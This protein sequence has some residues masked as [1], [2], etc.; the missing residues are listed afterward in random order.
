M[1]HQTMIHQT[2]IYQIQEILYIERGGKEQLQDEIKA[3]NP[4]VPKGNELVAT[5]M[6][7]IDNE[8][9]FEIFPANAQ[10]NEGFNA[11]NEVITNAVRGVSNVILNPATMNVDFAD[12]QAAMSQK[13]MAIMCIGK[14]KGLNRA[15]DAVNNALDN[16]FFNKAEVKNAKGLLINI[17]GASGMEMQEIN[18]IMKQAQSISQQ[19]VEA[20]PG[21]TIDESY[22]D[23]IVVTIIATG[24]RKFNLDEFS[25][26]Y[27]RPVRDIS[28]VRKESEAYIDPE[29]L[30]LIDIHNVIRSIED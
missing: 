25:N 22:G 27:I 10:F 29:R 7:E 21:L 24:L 4:L 15:I 3:Y 30:N 1:I 8:K 19:G 23:E 13:G 18:E 20:I 16:P 28:P 11:V 14:A 26:S 17:C 2:M 5:L 6:F 9:I 12:V